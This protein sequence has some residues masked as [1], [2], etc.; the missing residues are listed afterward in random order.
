VALDRYAIS[1]CDFIGVTENEAE[2]DE[3]VAQQRGVKRCLS[4]KAIGLSNTLLIMARMVHAIS[5]RSAISAFTLLPL[6]GRADETP[7]GSRQVAV[8]VDDLPGVVRNATLRDL[9]K[10]N[11]KIVAAL[12]AAG[13]PAVGFVNEHGLHVAGE[14]DGRAGIL[15]TWLAGG[16]GLGNHTY[17]HRG[18]TETPLAE[19]Q[20]DVLRGE[21]LT[22]GLLEA[23]GQ[24]LSWFRHPFGQAGPTEETKQGLERF[25]KERGYRVAPVTV[26]HADW[27][28]AAVFEKARAD[29]DPVLA[30][31]VRASYLEHFEKSCRWYESLSRDLFGRE[32]PQVLVTH[33]NRLNAERLPT[34]LANLRTRG[35]RFV[36][37]E[38]ALADPAYATADRYVGPAGPSWLHRWAPALGKQRRM[39]T[40][41]ELPAD[42]VAISRGMQAR[43]AAPA[44]P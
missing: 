13:V 18:M 31:R 38:A 2:L 19:F 29:R 16:M 41:P 42:I 25:L 27:V 5:R 34:L 10:V 21:V 6:A 17:R 11:E 36:T 35:Y 8:T 23:R 28:F 15:E 40:E 26:Y 43:K 4:H 9:Q 30:D 33:V 32:I 39:Q 3:I 12:K 24:K 37:L 1:A 22:R 44:P 7:S 14:R 20:D